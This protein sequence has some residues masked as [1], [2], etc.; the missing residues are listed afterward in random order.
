MPSPIARRATPMMHNI[1]LTPKIK[2]ASR[3]V[4][5]FRIKYPIPCTPP[6]TSVVTTPT[7]AKLIAF[8]R[9]ANV[10]TK[11]YRALTRHII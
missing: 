11:T 5:P 2:P 7:K 3:L 10:H 1:I 8:G 9:A 6:I 4:I